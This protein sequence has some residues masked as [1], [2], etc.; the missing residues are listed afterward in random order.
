MKTLALCIEKALVGLERM[1]LRGEVLVAD[2]G[3]T[4]GSVAIAE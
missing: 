1:G 4:D 2:N 3:S